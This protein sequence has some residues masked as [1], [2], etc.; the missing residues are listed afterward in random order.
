[1]IAA[2]SLSRFLRRVPPESK[3][4]RSLSTQVAERIAEEIRRGTWVG[5]LPSERALT[6]SLQVSRKT[7]RKAMAHLQ[8]DGLLEATH[9]VGR[10]IKSN[11]R[12]GK[13]RETSVGLLTPEA[14]DHLPS[15][16]SLWVGE[17]RAMLFEAGVRLAAF[18]GHS[19]FTRQPA[20][21]LTQLVRQNPQ[22]CWILTHS[23][24]DVQRWFFER[25]V[26]TLVAGSS[27]HGSQL[28]SVDLNYFAVCRHAAGAMLRQGHRRL[29]LLINES[30]RAGDLESE[31]GFIDGVRSSTLTDM[32]PIVIRHDGT[33]P[34]ALR[35]LARL[36]DRAAPPTALLVGKPT[37][38]LTAFSFLAGRG[39]RVPEDVS[40]VSRDHDSLLPFLTPAPAS[41][42]LS[43]KT[44]AKRLFPLVL[45]LAAGDVIPH[46]AQ[47][48][49][50]QFVTGPSL[51]P[52]RRKV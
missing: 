11:V 2:R 48:I 7:L 24:E 4:Y 18:S 44:Y 6:D 46:A 43:P 25:Q 8:Q 36:F 33:V 20:K 22:A 21:A 3:S 32:D 50:P 34:G 47:R 1:M 41:Y 29:A 51:A 10:R 5:Q 40:L 45:S 30:H 35:M 42:V 49:E 23:N 9:R 52:P 26:R 12:P 16:T 17:L 39:L 27:Y 31:A 37:I 13:R 15:N 14:L 19:F 38:Y 28:P